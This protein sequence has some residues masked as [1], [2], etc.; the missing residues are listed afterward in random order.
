MPKPTPEK[1]EKKSFVDQHRERMETVQE[2]VNGKVPFNEDAHKNAEE[3][4]K[5]IYK[6]KPEKIERYK[7]KILRSL[8]K[9][10]AEGKTIE[11]L[12]SWLKEQHCT[13]T[14]IIKGL[15]RFFG[16]TTDE[17]GKKVEKELNIAGFLKPPRIKATSEEG[18]S[19]AM[20]HAK[21][22]QNTRQSLSDLLAEIQGGEKPSSLA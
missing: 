17:E 13:T 5:V 16:E 9:H 18:E 4:A 15:L 14:A 3:L 20:L 1:K 12:W 7:E 22:I 8:E 10:L 21:E 2:Q 6:D 11:D 19:I